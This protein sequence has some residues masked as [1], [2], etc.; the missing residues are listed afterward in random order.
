MIAFSIF[1]L[2][3]GDCDGT[4]IRAIY[5]D[6]QI[7]DKQFSN[8]YFRIALLIDYQ[9]FTAINVFFIFFGTFSAYHIPNER[10]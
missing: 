7:F 9:P 4:K 3:W 2:F 8:I 5:L 6:F 10:I 1:L